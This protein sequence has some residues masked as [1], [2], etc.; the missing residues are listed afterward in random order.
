MCSSGL[1][2]HLET[3]PSLGVGFPLLYLY[4]QP[5][6]YSTPVLHT[7]TGVEYVSSFSPFVLVVMYNNYWAALIRAHDLVI[8][9]HG[10]VIRA[11][12]L[13]IRAHDLVIRAHGLLNR[14]HVLLQCHVLSWFSN[15][16]ARINKS[17][18]RIT[19]SCARITKPCA[20]ISAAQ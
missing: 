6:T 17:C 19:N 1:K 7:G 14:A 13:V 11:H 15:L 2:L 9:A 20:R 12:E 8:R 3:R 18:A 16:C 5:L 10:L 4:L